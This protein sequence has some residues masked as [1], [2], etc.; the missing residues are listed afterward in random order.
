MLIEILN[1]I[2]IVLCLFIIVYLVGMNNYIT[3]KY[4]FIKQV[5]KRIAR[6]K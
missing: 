5:L 3:E 1:I 2:I 6:K 4:E